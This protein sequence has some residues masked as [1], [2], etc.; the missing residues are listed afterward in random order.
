MDYEGRIQDYLYNSLQT[1]WEPDLNDASF[2][3]E[4]REGWEHHADHDEAPE[5]KAAVAHDKR[6]ARS[7][8]ALIKREDQ[9]HNC[10]CQ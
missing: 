4:L 8:A 3:R 6:I 2:F 10:L 1:V 9:A 5:I 7:F